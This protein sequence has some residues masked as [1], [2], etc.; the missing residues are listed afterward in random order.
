MCEGDREVCLQAAVAFEKARRAK[1][2]TCGDAL[3]RCNAES[4]RRVG[5][6][7]RKDGHRDDHDRNDERSMPIVLASL[8]VR[9]SRFAEEPRHR[10]YTILVA[11]KAASASIE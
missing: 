5:Q 9:G 4:A 1:A 6:Q 7:P 10:G 2:Q 3:G 11:T 8:G